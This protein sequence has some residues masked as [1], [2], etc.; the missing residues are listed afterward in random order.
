MKVAVLLV[1]AAAT[2]LEALPRSADAPF[3][4][5]SASVGLAWAV[6]RNFDAPLQFGGCGMC[7]GCGGGPFGQHSFFLSAGG[8][9]YGSA[10]GCTPSAG[11]PHGSCWIL[12]GI[13]ETPVWDLMEALKSGRVDVVADLLAAPPAFV[14][15]HADRG[16]IQFESPCAPG[17]V[18][19]HIP[20]NIVQ[21]ATA[22]EVA[23][24]KASHNWF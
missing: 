22:R 13:S 24:G 17:V 12:T 20:L 4:G 5:R 3:V 18:I 19:A 8:F 9:L 2:S 21:L 10:H 14:A 11:C 6:T 23:V 16:A 1:A 15:F 7:G